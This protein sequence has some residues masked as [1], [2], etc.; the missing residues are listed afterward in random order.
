MWFSVKYAEPTLQE[1]FVCQRLCCTKELICPLVFDHY[2]IRIFV[3]FFPT[4]HM[5]L[6]G[7]K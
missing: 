4:G 1:S 6:F 5:P 3:C 7:G 2:L